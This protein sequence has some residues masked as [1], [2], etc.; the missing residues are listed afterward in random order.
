[1]KDGGMVEEIPHDAASLPDASSWEIWF[2][3]ASIR[4][5][6]EELVDETST[7]VETSVIVEGGSIEIEEDAPEGYST[8]D[9]MDD[10]R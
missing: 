2:T 10:D 8:M 5:V 4:R 1:M 7:D 9:L 6:N 3:Y